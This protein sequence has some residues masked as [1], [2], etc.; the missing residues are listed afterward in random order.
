MLATSLLWHVGYKPAL[1]CTV[2]IWEKGHVAH[3]KIRESIAVKP[4]NKLYS[5]DSRGQLSLK[6]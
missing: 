2:S 1:A 4:Q 3:Q 5:R 6:I